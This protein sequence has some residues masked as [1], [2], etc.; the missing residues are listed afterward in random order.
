MKK[1]KTCVWADS[2]SGTKIFC[3]FPSCVKVETLNKESIL[4]ALES[5]KLALQD[6][7]DRDYNGG[8]SGFN[9]AYRE[10]RYWI[11]AIE[12]GEFD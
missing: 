4:K 2:R 9:E 5:R 12:R 10:V 11:G 6:L 3:P 8:I 7:I 1:C